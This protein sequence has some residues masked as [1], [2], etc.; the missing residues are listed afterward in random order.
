MELLPGF[1]LYNG[2]YELSQHALDGRYRETSGM[3]WSNLYDRE[4][5]MQ[6]TLNVMAL[7]WLILIFL[8]YSVEQYVS[9]HTTSAS[10]YLEY[11]WT[12]RKQS[13]IRFSRK[14]SS[15][16][17]MSMKNREV[18]LEVLQLST[19]NFFNLFNT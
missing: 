13:Q 7:E 3:R 11:F 15:L 5:G 2:L 16:L 8:A 9:S 17:H 10:Q 1:S 4:N 14:D 19:N 18:A 6:G 12:T